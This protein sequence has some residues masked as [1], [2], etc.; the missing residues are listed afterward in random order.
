MK[1][2]ILT[3]AILAAL[4]ASAHAATYCEADTRIFNDGKR[5]VESVKTTNLIL[6]DSGKPVA[7]VREFTERFTHDSATVYTDTAIACDTRTVYV[8]DSDPE[9]NRWDNLGPTEGYYSP[10]WVAHVCGKH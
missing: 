6:R 3:L 2:S 1:R 9:L 8:H 7:T 4:G 5:C 10:A